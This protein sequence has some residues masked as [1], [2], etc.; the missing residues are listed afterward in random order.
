MI[1][2]YFYKEGYNNYLCNLTF[3]KNKIYNKKFFLFNYSR[4][5][6]L[7]ILKENNISTNDKI[8]M[9][10]YQC[11]TVIDSVLPYSSNII[12]Y[13]IKDDLTFDVN[14]IL[15]IIEN[16][17]IKVIVFVHYFGV[18]ATIDKDL[19]ETLKSKNI[20]IIQD[21]AHC[22]LSFYK[23]DF[24]LAYPSDYIISSIYKNLSL[25][26]GAICIGKLDRYNNGINLKE[27]LIINIKR[28]LTNFRCLIGM[29]SFSYYKLNDDKCYSEKITIYKKNS[30]LTK[31][32]KNLIYHI[33][34]DKI[35]K[36]REKITS[37]YY[38]LFDNNKYF[39]NIFNKDIL[40][41][42]VLQAYP[43]LCLDQNVREKIFMYLKDKCI[44]VYPWPSYHCLNNNYYLKSKLLLFP[45]D[46]FSFEQTKK[47]I[48][49]IKNENI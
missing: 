14:E 27:F 6:I 38:D 15:S 44:D 3:S 17:D 29:R 48:E 2:R 47:F 20:I 25:G 9:P 41:N 13:N 5:A 12:F 32:Y 31:L 11:N 36:K 42:N 35:I 8:L 18:I 39:K 28:V 21:L 26:I 34:L 45:I 23:N 46:N 16:N 22:F 30:I 43:V 4:E 19:I 10:I 40:Q 1:Y 7:S 24:K 49:D 37:L 33:N